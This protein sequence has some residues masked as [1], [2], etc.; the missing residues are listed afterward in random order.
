[1][2]Q[3]KRIYDQ[4]KASDGY[5]ILVDRLW[6]RGL[7]KEQAAL[8]AWMKDIAPSPELRTWFNHDPAKLQEF[9]ARYQTELEQSP[10]LDLILHITRQQ[11][12]VT[13]LYAAKDPNI[14]HAQVLLSFL[15]SK[16]H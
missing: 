10:A 5:R 2:L 6:P 13:L 14:N 1:M 15:R 8:D 3:I 12:I 7:T 11:E 4:P 16:P 9:R